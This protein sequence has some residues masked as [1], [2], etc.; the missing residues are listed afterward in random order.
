MNV[1]YDDTTL[2][3]LLNRI[4]LQD[5]LALKNLYD[6][7]AML[8]RLLPKLEPAIISGQCP[9]AFHFR[10]HCRSSCDFSQM[11]QRVLRIWKTFGGQM[12]L[13]VTIADGKVSQT[14]SLTVPPS[15]FVVAI[16]NVIP[17]SL[18]ARSCS[19]RTHQCRSG[20][21]LPT[22]FRAKLRA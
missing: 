6:E 7:C 14:G 9:T 1:E 10:H 8:I 15:C 5:Q 13:S 11:T 21:G 4:A 20:F 22:S 17:H 16:A 19:A 18:Q 3:A 12:A 2:I